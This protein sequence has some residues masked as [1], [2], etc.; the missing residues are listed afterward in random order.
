ME[1]NPFLQ[2]FF[3]NQQ[4]MPEIKKVQHTAPLDHKPMSIKEFA[5][6]KPTGKDVEKYFKDKI[7]QLETEEED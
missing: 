7:Q 1:H 3:K 2:Q 4:K 5:K 6:S